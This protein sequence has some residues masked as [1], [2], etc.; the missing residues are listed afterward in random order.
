MIANADLLAAVGRIAIL[1]NELEKV[2][3]DILRLYIDID[4]ITA[5]LILKP[6]RSTDKAKLLKTVY[7]QKETDD[8][9]LEE[10][11]WF[12]NCLG[13]YRENRNTLIHQIDGDEENLSAIAQKRIGALADGLNEFLDYTKL[14]FERVQVYWGERA[15]RELPIDGMSGP[16][17]DRPLE[18]FIAPDRPDKP[19]KFTLKG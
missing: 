17:E 14:L 10:L 1:W 7:S 5:T 3:D 15:D 4:E 13:I 18:A 16:D 11:N 9:V 2:S 8:Y 19:R 12:I 6:M